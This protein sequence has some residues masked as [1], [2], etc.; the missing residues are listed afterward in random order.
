MRV[1]IRFSR[2]TFRSWQHGNLVVLTPDNAAIVLPTPESYFDSDSGHTKKTLADAKTVKNVTKLARELAE[3]ELRQI[4]NDE[5][6]V[7]LIPFKLDSHTD[8]LLDYVIAGTE[9]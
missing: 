9:E 5:K 2:L 8:R 3:H 7:R 6:L 4:V 1:Y